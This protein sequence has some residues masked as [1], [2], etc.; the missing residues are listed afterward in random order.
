MKRIQSLIILFMALALAACSSNAST[1]P[2]P[3]IVLDGGNANAT[4]PAPSASTSSGGNVSASA[5][6]VPAQDAQ[7]A[8]PLAGTIQKVYVTAGD[9]VKAGDILMELDNTTIQLEV[10]AA[11]RTVRELTSA[12]SIAAAEQAVANTQKEYDDAKKKADSIKY[13]RTDNVTINYLKDQVTLAQD[14]LDRAREAYNLTNKRSS[15]DPVRAKAATNLYNAQKAYNVAL[16]NLN[17]YANPPSETDVALAAANF[18]AANAALQEANWYLAELKGETIPDNATGAQLAQ[19]QQ[20]RA[21]LQIA[22]EKLEQTRLRASISGIVTSVD[23]V[24]G[25]YTMPGQALIAIS[26]V[27]NLRIKTTD[28]SERDVTRV[29][30]GDPVIITVDAVAQ[31]FEGKVIAISPVSTTLGGDVV[32]EVTIEFTEKPE[33][34][35]GGMSAEVSIGE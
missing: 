3:T 30:I 13:R 7:L 14:A 35:L 1:T 6:V 23:G 17:W 4:K 18:D 34:L 33:G 12:A 2:I 22:Q 5:V 31:D 21:S 26:D 11:Q 19:L 16:G 10:E 28:L 15:V 32:Y 8:F 25:E 24:A 29:K 27:N 9:Q 20:A